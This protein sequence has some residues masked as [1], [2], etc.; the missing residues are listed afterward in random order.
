[1]GWDEDDLDSLFS[2]VVGEFAYKRDQHPNFEFSFISFI[3]DKRLSLYIA[4]RFRKG[5]GLNH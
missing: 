1:M 2:Q 4:T 5:V 3:K